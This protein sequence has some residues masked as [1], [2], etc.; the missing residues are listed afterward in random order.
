M[1]DDVMTVRVIEGGRIV[2]PA[3]VRRSLQIR[4][5]DALL[6]EVEADGIKLR[7]RAES[8]RRARERMA[9]F[10]DPTRSRADELIAERR[11]EAN[12]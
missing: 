1:A 10:K 3:A 4:E 8:L 12:G 2:I 11:A 9:R 5:G 7:T 6:L